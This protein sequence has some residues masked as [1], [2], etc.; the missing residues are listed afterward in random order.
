MVYFRGLIFANL[1]LEMMKR[2]ILVFSCAVA[3]SIFST[4][5]SWAQG[6]MR[7]EADFEATQRAVDMVKIA[8]EIEQAGYVLD[9]EEA[10]AEEGEEGAW[11]GADADDIE[12]TNIAAEDADLLDLGDV[13]ILEEEFET[14]ESDFAEIKELD[15]NGFTP[16]DEFTTESEEESEEDGAVL[17]LLDETE[18]EEESPWW[19]DNS[20]NENWS[21]DLD[22][23]EL[24]ALETSYEEE[25]MSSLEALY[26]NG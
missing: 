20:L 6:P 17:G 10:F 5:N 18:L 7:G 24:E 19:E 23:W 16:V 3:A 1:T 2:S 13:T 12:I 26:E 14:E 15:E 4:S 11:I 9:V 22:E 25:D 8:E 21:E